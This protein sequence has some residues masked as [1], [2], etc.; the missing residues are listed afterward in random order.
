MSDDARAPVRP[1]SPEYFMTIFAT[2]MSLFT[3]AISVYIC[4]RLLLAARRTRGA[5]EFAMGTYQLF[6]V[7][8]IVVYTVVRVLAQRGQTEDLFRIVAGANLLIALG[9]VALAVGVWRIYRP[10]QT[11]AAVLCSGF[12]IA[13]LIGWA[14][15]SVGEILP[16]TAAA[17]TSNA[18]FVATRSAVYLWGGFEGFHYHRMMRRRV[19]LGLGDPVVAHQILLWGFFSLA[20]GS[21]AVTTLAAGYLLGDAYSTWTPALFMTPVVSLIASICL[22]LGFFPPASYRR[23]VGSR[24]AIATA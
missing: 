21:L 5:A 2:S 16:T 10:S 7:A 1:K 23:L 14:W 3:I 15:T 8:A 22:W 9:V 13:V 20:M 24:T 19:A 12:S 18:F 4:V 17:T 6:V 11:W